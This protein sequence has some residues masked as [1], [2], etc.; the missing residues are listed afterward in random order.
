[1]QKVHPLSVEAGSGIKLQ[2]IVLPCC[3][4]GKGV[5]GEC[6]I[7]GIFEL[8]IDLLSKVT[9]VVLDGVSLFLG[10]VTLVHLRAEIS[11]ISI[12]I[13][14]GKFIYS[15]LKRR[16]RKDDHIYCILEF[17]IYT[18]SFILIISSSLPS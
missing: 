7:E 3:E 12:L 4:F 8:V 11:Q 1:M 2:H 14:K 17:S 13:F 9:Q 10:L 16:R 15:K 6:E 18:Y 5:V